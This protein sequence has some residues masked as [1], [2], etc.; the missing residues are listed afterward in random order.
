MTRTTYRVYTDDGS[1]FVFE[2]D[3]SRPKDTFWVDLEDDLKPLP[4]PYQQAD[5]GDPRSAARHL[6]AY[7]DGAI[8]TRVEK[9]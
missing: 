4:T 7:V 9:C 6:A 1:S 2:F 5:F 3:P 8:V